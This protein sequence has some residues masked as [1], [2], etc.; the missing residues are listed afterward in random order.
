MKSIVLYEYIRQVEA[1]KVE[2][3][4]SGVRLPPDDEMR[5]SGR[6]RTPE[7][8]E[9]LRRCDERAIAAGKKPIRQN[10]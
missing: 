6:N 10:Y 1:R 2:L 8:R 7:K 9:L 3:R 5:N 4:A